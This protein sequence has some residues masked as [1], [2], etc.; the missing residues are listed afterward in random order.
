MNYGRND[1]FERRI[2]GPSKTT[3][4][5]I[6]NINHVWL[7]QELSDRGGDGKGPYIN[8]VIYDEAQLAIEYVVK[9]LKWPMERALPS[10]D[11]NGEIRFTG[12]FKIIPRPVITRQIEESRPSLETKLSEMTSS[13]ENMN[14]QISSLKNILGHC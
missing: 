2:S 12:G 4:P 9:Q 1:S 14:V 8:R 13:V 7:V 3:K 11:Q 5:E 6:P 10:P